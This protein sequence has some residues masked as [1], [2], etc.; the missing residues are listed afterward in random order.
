MLNNLCTNINCSFENIFAVIKIM[1]EYSHL[2]I[3][4]ITLLSIYLI[5]FVYSILRG[6]WTCFLGHLLGFGVKWRSGDN[7]WAVITGA[8][9]GIGLE[10][11]KQ[12]AAKGYSL[13]IMSRNEDKLRIVAKRIK[14]QFLMCKQVRISTLIK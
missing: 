6:I 7:V 12:L 1:S 13:M 4:A 11:A 9:D 5:K 3:I 8:T 14:D 2:E 10:Y